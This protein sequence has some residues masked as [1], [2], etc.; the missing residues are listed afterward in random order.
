VLTGGNIAPSPPV[1]VAAVSGEGDDDEKDCDS[2]RAAS[3]W[4]VSL[5]PRNNVAAPAWQSSSVSATGHSA[6]ANTVRWRALSLAITRT[7]SG[8]SIVRRK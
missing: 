7:V 5:P 2:P 1:D 6:E 4:T 3:G 8:L